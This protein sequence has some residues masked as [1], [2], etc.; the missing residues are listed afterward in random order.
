MDSSFCTSVTGGV[1]K[2][3]RLNVTTSDLPLAVHSTMTAPAT[4]R[5]Q[6]YVLY[7]HFLFEF[8]MRSSTIGCIAVC[9]VNASSLGLQLVLFWR[10]RL[11]VY[12]VCCGGRVSSCRLVRSRF[13]VGSGRRVSS[14]RR[15][16][17]RLL[18]DSG[19]RVV[20]CIYL[21][22]LVTQTTAFQARLALLHCVG[23]DLRVRLKIK[24]SERS[25]DR[26]EWQVERNSGVDD[27]WIVVIKHDDRRGGLAADVL[28]EVEVS[29]GEKT[30]VSF[31]DLVGNERAATFAYNVG[32]DLA[33]EYEE[34]LG[35]A[36]MVMR[37]SETAGFELE[38]DLVSAATESTVA[39]VETLEVFAVGVALL[40]AIT[41]CDWSG[42]RK[43]NDKVCV[44]KLVLLRTKR[45]D[46]GQH[47][48]HSGGTRSEE[49]KSSDYNGT[50][51]YHIGLV[52]RLSAGECL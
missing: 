18:V 40:A 3:E 33:F 2:T 26:I 24:V 8:T 25:L 34:I 32:R 11:I 21:W 6:L 52:G 35:A 15:R 47:A 5:K 31:C 23:Y 27:A 49:R 42:S 10:D 30:G 43:I 22:F 4:A 19:R 51:A 28:Q 36:R 29:L 46:V 48:A 50:L 41:S 12:L 1:K 13:P 44:S 9:M 16:R 17:G 20:S 39:Q 37:G 38:E 45:S 7:M 14:G